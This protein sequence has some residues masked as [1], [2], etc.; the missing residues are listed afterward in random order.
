M[1][2]LEGRSYA[3]I[4]D[5]IGVSVSAVETLIFRARKTL[6]LK[7]SSLRSLAAVPLPTSLTRLF[8]G[9]GVVAGGGAA[10]GAGLVLKA[11]RRDRRRGSRHRRWRRPQSPRH[12]C[13][14][15]G[16]G[17]V[18]APSKKGA[19]DGL[20]TQQVPER[21]RSSSRK[22]GER[23]LARSGATGRGRRPARSQPGPARRRLGKPP[24]PPPP[25]ATS[26]VRSPRSPHRSPT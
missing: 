22:R 26:P 16:H 18:L 3:E 8:E 10:A 7:A 19:D 23:G 24:R 17:L 5:T 12:C 14:A 9:G 1:R 2:E 13:D 4:A 15:S 11:A 20:K 25:R 21:R 6:R